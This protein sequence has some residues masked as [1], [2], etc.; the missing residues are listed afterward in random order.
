MAKKMLIDATHAEETR[1]VVVDG[2]KVEEFDF[3]SE[4][5]RQLAGNIYLAKVTRVE[6]SLQ[7]AFV[8]YGGNRHG[9]L[10]FSEI[11]PDYYQIPVADRE[12]LMEE[13]RA[14]AEA[15]KARDEEEEARPKKRRRRTS[16]KAEKTANSD[17]VE[18][19]E[20]EGMETID[21]EADDDTLEGLSPMETVAETPVEE[22]ETAAEG[23]EAAQATEETPAEDTE[24]ARAPEV[25]TEDDGEDET[26]AKP[27]AADKDSDI[28]SVA[29]DDDHEDIR[30]PRKPRPRRYKIQEVIK[31]RQ[32]LLVQV[33]KEERG[34]KGAALTTYLSLAGR[35]CVLMPN[36][37]R[38]GGIS[39]KITNA[40]DRKKL[41]EIAGEIDVPQ[42]AGL[43]IRTAGAKRTKS[44]IKRD[45]EYLQRLWEQIR[46]L[47]LKSIAPAKI[48]EEGDLIKRSIRDLYSRD[49]DEVLVEGER[50]YR[51]AKDFMK[52]IMPSHAKNVKL[53][54]EQ[55]P[56]FARFQVES[57]LGAMFN[58]TVQLKSGGYIVIGVTEALVA[59][60]VNSGRATKEGSIEE[61]ATKT[62]LEAAEEVARQ[63]RLRD[64]A[65]LIVI[66]FIDMD[67]RKNNAAV[68]KKI[69]DKLKTDRA[70]IQVGRISGFGLM[71][72]SRQRLRPGMIEATTA[73]CPHCHGTGLIRS[74]DSLAL[75]VL[76]Q[77]EEEGT[78]R[79]CK[80][81]LVRC[82]VNI[83]NY[84]MNAKR[85]HI[86]LIEARY[87]I[88][89]RVEGDPSLV[90]PDF[91]IEKLKTATRKVAEAP[92]VSAD[93]TI[94]DL[95]DED[96]EEPEEEVEVAEEAPAEAETPETGEE[97]SPKP[98]KRRRRRRRRKSKSEEGNGDS[99]E[100]G[101]S[102]DNGEADSDEAEGAKDAAERAPKE[103]D[104]ASEDKP[105]R[106]R[107]TS[108]SRRKSSRTKAEEAPAEEATVAEATPVEAVEAAAEVSDAPEAEA[109]ETEAATP[110][111]EVAETAEAVTSEAEAP[112]D[113]E[114]RS[115]TPAE[116]EGQA[117][118]PADAE[119]DAQ[120]A[121]EA[122]AP[123]AAEADA[124]AE[125]EMQAEAP[126]AEVAPAQPEAETPV[127][128]EAETPVQPAA[129]TPVQPAA[130]TPAEPE[131][132][133]EPKPEAEAAQAPA[134]EPEAP[135]E[136]EATPEP[137]LETVDTAQE[138]E[139]DD[140]KPK[141][142][143]WWSIGR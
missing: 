78:R 36:T 73:P 40:P 22:P 125:P 112:A 133:A 138:P 51:I 49:I 72:M 91:T 129:E 56:L 111:Q 17:A 88:A 4:N 96:A 15:M 45:Y 55:L 75:Q 127:Q 104:D 120:S 9:F 74:D 122:H 16:L 82:P 110:V 135:A 76:R 14:Y 118:A 106:T 64:L 109:P 58:P 83:A 30:P 27:D 48:Y 23:E 41:K 24:D 42:G 93:T 107:R 5:K 67:E 8:D 113:T 2:N 31:V 57:Y 53:Y 69:K 101:D 105:K 85:E 89:V 7:A 25:E 81:L 47:T 136:P 87:G 108:S 94:M 59:I 44:E 3:E 33:V 134:A 28:E 32:I 43:I 62:N 18:S 80:E 141:K 116:P 68:E 126:A 119:P 50:G 139:D 121:P 54:A 60:D 66:D 70:R 77:L 13:E 132:E 65:G 131:A 6:P 115:D 102:Q 142:R 1:V 20:V 90:S 124:P 46:E 37:A 95:V 128:P 71:E 117:E 10:A 38:G 34:N 11:H 114:L 61:T 39:R 79:R 103:A 123:V 99:Q 84:L 35:Y 21:L 97:E 130:E 143:G 12:A 92:V 86:A 63:L 100:N 26:P 29:D 137:V 52:M 140:S 19:R 98:K